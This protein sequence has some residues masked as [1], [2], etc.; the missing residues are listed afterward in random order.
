MERKLLPPTPSYQYIIST[1]V[2]VVVQLQTR[3]RDISSS[4]GSS[5]EARHTD[6]LRRMMIIL[7]NALDTI[8]PSGKQSRNDCH[9]FFRIRMPFG[10]WSKCNNSTNIRVAV[11]AR[12]PRAPPQTGHEARRRP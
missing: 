7:R 3:N 5:S 8:S 2:D 6:L 12:R 10:S 1:F 11:R 4:T 9:S